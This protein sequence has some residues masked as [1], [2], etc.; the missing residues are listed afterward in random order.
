MFIKLHTDSKRRFILTAA[1][2]FLALTACGNDGSTAAS[3]GGSSAYEVAGDHAIGNPDASVTVVEYASVVCGACANFHQT[4]YPDFKKKYI[5]SGLVR[6]VFREYPTSIASPYNSNANGKSSK[7]RATE[8][9]AK[10]MLQLQNPPAYPKRNL[11]LACKT[12]KK[13]T[14]IKPL[15]KAGLMR[16]SAARRAFSLMVSL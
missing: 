12:K 10:N 6:F 16:A 4:V 2:S 5:D 14:A 7:P 11:T 15:C 8:L 3:S 1:A 9:F 13:S